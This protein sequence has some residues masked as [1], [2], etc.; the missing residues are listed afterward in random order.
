[1]P[2]KGKSIARGVEEKLIGDIEEEGKVVLW[3]DSAI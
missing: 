2:Y 3:T 1:V